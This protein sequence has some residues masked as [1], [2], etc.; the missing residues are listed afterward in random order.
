MPVIKRMVSGGA[1][2]AYGTQAATRGSPTDSPPWREGPRSGGECHFLLLGDILPE[3]NRGRPD[4][5]GVS[6]EHTN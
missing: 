5:T 4:C 6:T 3:K 1:S 2:L